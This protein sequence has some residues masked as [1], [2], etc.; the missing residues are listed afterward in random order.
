[1]LE[2]VLEA[3]PVV[4]TVNV[5][6]VDPAATVIVAGTVAAALP[7]VKLTA[8][9]PVGAGPLRVTVPVDGDPPVTDVGLS[10]NVVTTGAVIARLA[11]EVL[12]PRVAVIVAEALADTAEVDTVNVPVVDPAATV[13]EAG[14]V[15]DALFEARFT[16]V[17]P[18]GAG[19]L[20]VAVPVEEVPPTTVVGLTAT[21]TVVPVVMVR[22]T[23]DCVP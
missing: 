19:A 21:E 5:P 12:A 14:T 8:S 6:V 3:T 18:A 20:I 17:P 4:V 22:V 15:A 9:P 16:T 2:V 13:T 1:M 23:I 10:P 11:V 7:E